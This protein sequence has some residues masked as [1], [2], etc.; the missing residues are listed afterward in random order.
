METH[1]E[2]LWHDVVKYKYVDPLNYEE[3]IQ[4]I[5]KS[6]SN[7]LIILKSLVL[8]FPL[9]VNWLV[10]KVGDVKKVCLGSEPWMRC[11]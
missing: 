4:S 2:G 8:Y 9:I 6:F 11:A 1:Q 3:W 7:A 5:A 10:W